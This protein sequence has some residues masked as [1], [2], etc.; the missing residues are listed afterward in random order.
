M[1]GTTYTP[2]GV[3][4]A[5]L[6][7]LEAE[8]TRVFTSAECAAILGCELRTVGAY[9]DYALRAERIFKVKIGRN[10]QYSATRMRDAVEP[11]KRGRRQVAPKIVTSTSWTTDQDDPRIGKVVDGWKPPVMRCVR[12]EA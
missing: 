10:V 2:R 5:L 12:L 8:P 1:S 3:V 11:R 4:V 6:D 9:V 7:A